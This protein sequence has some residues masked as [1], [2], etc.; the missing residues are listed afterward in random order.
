MEYEI[1]QEIISF[2]PSLASK[3]KIVERYVRRTIN[4]VLIFC[5]RE[6]IPMQLKDTIFDI[7]EASLKTDNHIETQKEVS[8]ITRGDTSISYVNS[9]INS[10]E[11]LLKD[12]E[13]QLVKFRKMKMLG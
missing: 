3:E 7:V 10:S 8:S 2:Y 4:A 6:D 13:K 11:T 1:V 12:F 9:D 5:N